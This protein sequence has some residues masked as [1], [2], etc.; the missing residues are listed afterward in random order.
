MANGL[1]RACAGNLLA[2]RVGF[3]VAT[4]T[5]ALYKILPLEGKEV[6]SP[7]TIRYAGNVIR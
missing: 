2:D 1:C 3:Q 4:A 6:P 7:D 5:M